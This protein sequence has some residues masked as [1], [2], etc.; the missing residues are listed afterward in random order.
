MGFAIALATMI[1]PL[2][3][4]IVGS[5]MIHWLILDRDSKAFPRLGWAI[6]VD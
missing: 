4:D 6:V 3:M 1:V 5:C 2:T